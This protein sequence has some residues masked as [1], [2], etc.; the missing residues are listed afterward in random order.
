M[1]QFCVNLPGNLINFPLDE[2]C[3]KNN[4]Y[5]TNCMHLRFKFY[6]YIHMYVQIGI[7]MK[8]HIKWKMRPGI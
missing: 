7:N 5:C 8:I 1:I 2:S 4:Q 3:C 6:M